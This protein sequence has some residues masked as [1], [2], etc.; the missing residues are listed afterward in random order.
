MPYCSIEEAWGNNFNLNSSSPAE[1]THSSSVLSGHNEDDEYFTLSHNLNPTHIEQ[2]ENT[3]D[4]VKDDINPY[5]KLEN[6]IDDTVLEK[7]ISKKQQV[8]S[9]RDD[10]DLISF[11]NQHI[12]KTIET[13]V[14]TPKFL[15]N[16]TNDK[17]MM[18]IVIYIIT[19][20]FIIFILD[21]FT[22][23]GKNN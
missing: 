11:K 3:C 20:I 16:E 22:K 4:K 19:G 23:L 6:I 21:I 7:K 12:D 14:D 1:P 17:N 2:L 10:T 9:Q 18:N 15:V 5:S 8:I 13:M